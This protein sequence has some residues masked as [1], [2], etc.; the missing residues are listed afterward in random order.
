M[1]KETHEFN[2][3]DTI[4]TSK[5][6]DMIY[7]IDNLNPEEMTSA[8]LIEFCKLDMMIQSRRNEIL[9]YAAAEAI[10]HISLNNPRD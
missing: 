8:E 9:S 3:D 5:F 6:E 2:F 10:M 1:T 7:D 4:L